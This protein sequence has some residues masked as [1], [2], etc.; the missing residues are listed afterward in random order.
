VSIRTPSRLQGYRA[1]LATVALVAAAVAAVILVRA[2]DPSESL[3]MSL[4]IGSSLVTF[5]PHG[6]LYEL[7][8]GGVVTD[9]MEVLQLRKGAS[10]VRL[11]GVRL[12]Q[13][14]DMRLL[15]A[16]VLGPKRKLYQ[17]TGMPGFPPRGRSGAKPAAG[18]TIGSAHR[19][20][21][22]LVGVEAGSA[23]YPV[24]HGIEVA[25]TSG[26]RAYR[27]VLQ[28]VLIVC[29]DRLARV[30]HCHPPASLRDPAP[31]S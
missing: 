10:R 11:L 26:G 27:Q 12:V 15:G 21:E 5:E 31:I 3:P 13:A 7:P 24:F 29:A 1:L 2:H 8:G 22:L 23:G 14:H 17:F 20:W 18:A 9:G 28:G 19:G 30:G 25:Y 6:D 4:P 16:R